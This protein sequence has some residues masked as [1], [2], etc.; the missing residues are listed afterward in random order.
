MNS[1]VCKD[2]ADADRAGTLQVSQEAPGIRRSLCLED[3]DEHPAGGTVD[4]H[5]QVAARGF[6]SHLRQILHVDVDITGLA[7]L[8]SAVFRPGRLGLQVAQIAHTMPA[9]AAVEPR[10]RD[11]RVQE[12]PHHGQQVIER[13]QQGLAQRHGHG[14]LRGRK[15]GLQAVLRMAA[16]LNAVALAPLPDGL[17]GRPVALCQNP[18]RLIARLDQGTNFGRRGC[19]FMQP[20][21]HRSLHPAQP[22][23]PNVP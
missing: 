11:I 17:F 20:D 7:S 3:A 23:K 15:R 16:I 12:L 14:F 10:A 4:G 8:E 9:K 6:V 22:P 21:V 2:C 18:G 5:K 1:F 13:D 19:L